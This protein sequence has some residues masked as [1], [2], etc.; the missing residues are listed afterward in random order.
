MPI[1]YV[2]LVPASSSHQL[3]SSFLSLDNA[4]IISRRSLKRKCS[5]SHRQIPE[6]VDE[7]TFYL[8]VFKARPPETGC[9]EFCEFE[10]SWPG[11]SIT[12]R[13]CC[14]HT[15]LKQNFIKKVGSIPP[16]PNVG[17]KSCHVM[18]VMCDTGSRFKPTGQQLLGWFYQMWF[19]N[20][21]PSCCFSPLWRLKRPYAVP[22]QSSGRYTDSKLQQHHLR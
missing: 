12:R 22:N 19:R 2:W 10:K 13:N 1:C 6:D 4:D 11:I 7:N 20:R 14:Q 3:S 15:Q 18:P 16:Y 17:L 8:L 5:H 9:T 21:G